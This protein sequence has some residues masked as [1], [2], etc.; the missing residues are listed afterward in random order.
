M[1]QEIKQSIVNILRKYLYISLGKVDY[2]LLKVNPIVILCY[3]SIADDGWAFSTSLEEMEA[4]MKLILKTH[5]P[6][7][8]SE[9]VEH[10]KYKKPFN[11]PVFA[12]TFDDGYQ[13]VFTAKKLMREL[14]IVPT[15]FLLSDIEKIDRVNLGTDLKFLS[16][17]EVKLLKKS[18]WQFGSHGS[19][20]RNL[21]ELS[22]E[23]TTYE[24][25]ES[26]RSIRKQYTFTPKTFA[27][28]KGR[29]N[30]SILRAVKKAGYVAAY[31]MDDGF[32]TPKTNI[33]KIPRV[34]VMGTHSLS[35]FKYM[36]SPLVVK[37]RMKI[38]QLIGLQSK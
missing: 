12:V 31:S 6:V 17:H 4:Q 7:K 27:Y 3:H 13:N 9:I 8:L 2:K 33:Y 14:E 24:V 30:N 35:E 1:H 16:K 22:L 29:Y 19:T 38:K 25:I 37:T 28:P 32:I 10:I 26:A 36:Y 34:G 23:D 21:N 11:R 5:R 20:H 18:N 15:I